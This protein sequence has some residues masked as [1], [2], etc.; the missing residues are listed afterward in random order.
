M[1]IRYEDGSSRG[2][3]LVSLTGAVM[4][5]ATERDEDLLEFRLMEGVWISEQC[6]AVTFEFPLGIGQHD[7]FRSLVADALRP[8]DRLAGFISPEPGD[9]RRVN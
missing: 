6:E 7:R 9:T 1:L 4:R 2:A 3:I 8:I 5:V